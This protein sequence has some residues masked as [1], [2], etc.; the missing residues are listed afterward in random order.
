MYVCQDKRGREFAGEQLL[1]AGFDVPEVAQGA[2]LPNEGWI[3]CSGG[4]FCADEEVFGRVFGVDKFYD[5]GAIAQY[6]QDLCAAGVGED[7]GGAS[8][9]DAVRHYGC[10]DISVELC[11]QFMLAAGRCEDDGAVPLH[12]AGNGFVGG[13][14]AGVKAKDDVG[15][16]L[17]CVAG[18]AGFVKGEVCPAEITGEGATFGDEGWVVVNANESRGDVLDVVQVVIRCECEIRAAAAAVYEGE[19][20]IR[21]WY[22]GL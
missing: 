4:F 20:A 6:S 17:G 21:F 16:C 15:R 1:E 18:D 9:E 12:G 7:V 3:I 10:E 11:A 22:D 5:F 13:C 8:F 19:G 14:V 2:I